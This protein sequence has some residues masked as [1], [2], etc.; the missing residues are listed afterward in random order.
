MLGYFLIFTLLA[1]VFSQGARVAQDGA[2]RECITSARVTYTA[3]NSDFLRRVTLET[4]PPSKAAAASA[5]P[6]SAQFSPQGTRWLALVGPD[7]TRPGPWH[8][9]IHLG[10]AGHSL[11]FLSLHFHDHSSGGV[12][13]MWLNEKLVFVRAWWGRVVSTDGVFDVQSQQWL[14]REDADY[15]AFTV[16]SL[17]QPPSFEPSISPAQPQS[18]C[19]DT[20]FHQSLRPRLTRRSSGPDCV[21]PLNFFR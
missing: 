9:T 2:F 8:S 6:S 18:R 14:Y 15:V 1:H 21:G 4:S 13:A 10:E 7:F 20:G 11:P 12:K 16:P 19:A 5:P 17:P 3:P